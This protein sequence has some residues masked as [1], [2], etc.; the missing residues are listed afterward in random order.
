MILNKRCLK[1]LAISL[2]IILISKSTLVPCIVAK[3]INKIKFT[4]AQSH[5]SRFWGNSPRLGYKKINVSY[6]CPVRSNFTRHFSV[7]N[8]IFIEIIE[9][10]KQK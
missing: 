4:I 1:I 6:K 8:A 10:V 5:N 9:I 2:D 3:I 7:S